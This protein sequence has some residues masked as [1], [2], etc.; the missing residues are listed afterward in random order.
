MHGSSL[1]D[2]AKRNLLLPLDD[3]LAHHQIDVADAV[4]PA[5]TAIKYNSTDL[6]RSVRRARCTGAPQLDLFKKAG[7]VNADGTPKLP[8]SAA[9]MLADAQDHEK[10]D[11]EKLS[12]RA[13]VG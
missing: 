2:Y 11:R 9:E 12:G 5:Q 1:V 3:L 7:L 6:R 8:T 4:P 10:E 13:A